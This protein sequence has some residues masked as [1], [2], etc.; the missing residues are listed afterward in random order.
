[1]ENATMEPK[2]PQKLKTSL[3]SRLHKEEPGFW[4]LESPVGGVLAMPRRFLVAID[5]ISNRTN[6]MSRERFD[7]RR[8]S[9]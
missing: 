8:I 2:K 1:M 3:P 7:A 4:Q 5:C 6:G 9:R